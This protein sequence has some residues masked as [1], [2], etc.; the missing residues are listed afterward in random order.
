MRKMKDFFALIEARRSVRAFESRPVEPAW[1]EKILRAA[2]R[3]PS[4]GNLQAYEV[5]IVRHPETI[6][7]LAGLCYNQSFIAQ[8]PVVLVF[9]AD[10]ARSS[11]K[12]GPKG[13]TLYAVQDATIAAAYA[14]LA[15]AALGL[16]T[17]WVG[18]FDEAELIRR[19]HL[20][21]GLRPIAVFPVGWPAEQP[22]RT[23][24]RPYEE[25]VHEYRP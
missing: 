22:P 19:L 3:A 8:A 13:E 1:I 12:Y 10:P 14:E 18:A 5:V 16:A 9:C 21:P 4:A 24:R 6:R 15:V 23:P 2:Q 25:V 7:A 17:C 20:R 11:A